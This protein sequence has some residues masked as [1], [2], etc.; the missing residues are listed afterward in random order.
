[1][2]ITLINPTKEVKL[3]N[4]LVDSNLSH[5]DQIGQE[6]TGK[7]QA[8]QKIVLE[9]II[10]AYTNNRNSLHVFCRLN[11]DV[12][13]AVRIWVNQKITNKSNEL[14]LPFGFHNGLTEDNQVKMLYKLR[15]AKP[16]N[17]PAIAVINRD[18]KYT[19]S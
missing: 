3:R 19:I 2:P 14:L 11:E 17:S 13:G 6:L 12:I 1:M 4:A 15:M 16:P 9:G 8:L 5:R 10:W 7:A 18:W